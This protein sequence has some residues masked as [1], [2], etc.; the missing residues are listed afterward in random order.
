M[1]S[2]EDLFPGL[3]L[4]Q[5]PPQWVKIRADIVRFGQKGSFSR[6]A[7]HVHLLFDGQA[8]IL[9]KMKSVRNLYSLRRS[10]AGRLCIERTTIPA[11]DL[12]F[13]MAAQLF[14]ATFGDVVFQSVDNLSTSQIDDD[15][16]VVLRFSPFPQIVADDRCN[17]SIVLGHTQQFPKDRVVAYPDAQSVPAAFRR[18]PARSASLMN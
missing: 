12:D 16:P 4:S 15:C 10:L 18:T 2:R 17:W 5:E 11:D 6:T 7:I 3:K 14:R 1:N 9:Y 8:E 13:W